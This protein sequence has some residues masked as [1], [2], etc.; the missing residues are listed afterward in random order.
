MAGKKKRR[1]TLAVLLA[2]LPFS[3]LYLGLS[4]QL[5]AADWRTATKLLVNPQNVSRRIVQSGKSM[6]ISAWLRSRS[7]SSAAM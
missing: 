5:S 3:F 7:S 6:H 1:V 2:Y 4:G